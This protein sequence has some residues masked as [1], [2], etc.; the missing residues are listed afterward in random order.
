MADDDYNPLKLSTDGETKTWPEI[1]KAY[2]DKAMRECRVWLPVT[3]L[4][5]VKA[6]PESVAHVAVQPTLLRVFSSSPLPVPIPVPIPPLQNLPVLYPRGT[7]WGMRYPIVPGDSG[8]ALFCDR[9]LDLWKAQPLPLPID[10]QNLRTHDLSDGVFIPGLYPLLSPEAP[11]LE[12]AGALDF[13]VYNGLAQLFLQPAGGFIQGNGVVETYTLQVALLTAIITAA[14]AAATAYTAQAAAFA[15][16]AAASTG[17]LAGLAAGFTTLAATATA[18]AV[19]TTA[20]VTALTPVQAG[21][22]ALKGVPG[23]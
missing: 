14:T 6:S 10:P 12:T 2:I 16:Q 9:S 21:F 7:A 23:A 17:P 1:Y 18:L 20:L 3:V 4:S 13:A 15:V 22:T 5:V 19:S 11:Q 8:I